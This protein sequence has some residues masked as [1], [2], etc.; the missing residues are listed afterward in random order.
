M[1]QQINNFPTFEAK[2]LYNFLSLEECHKVINESHFSQTNQAT[3]GFKE[4]VNKSIRDTLVK[5][6]SSSKEN[7]W[8]LK[9]LAENISYANNLFYK[10]DLTVL[11]EVQ[12]LEYGIGGFYKWH[13]DIKLK[14]NGDGTS[15]KLSFVVFL[16]NPN[17]YEG[18]N[19]IINTSKNEIKM[20]Q[21]SMIIFPSFIVHKVE[22]VTKGKR[23]T[24]VGWVHGPMFR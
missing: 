1:N 4:E 24:L 9:R 8:L 2:I 21:G 11:N 16:T 10:F 5:H 15:R 20:E 7:E 18:G 6:I 3:I 14:G 12:L 22:P 17:E 19:L 23:H 13:S